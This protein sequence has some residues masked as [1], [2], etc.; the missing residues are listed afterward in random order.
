MGMDD[1]GDFME[2]TEIEVVK[3]AQGM[4]IVHSRREHKADY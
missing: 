4:Q 3:V 2:E 1:P